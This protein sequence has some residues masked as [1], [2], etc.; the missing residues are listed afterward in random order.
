MTVISLVVFVLGA[1]A[2]SFLNVAIQRVPE[3]ITLFPP[4]STCDQCGSRLQMA[5]R[6][7]LLSFLVLSGRCRSCEGRR[8]WQYPLVELLTAILFVLVWMTYG[9][10]WA[11]LAGWIFATVMVA[12]TI[13][14]IRHMIIPNEVLAAGA[15]LGLPFLAM[16]SLSK[17]AWGLVAG[18][19]LG[20]AMLLIAWLSKGGMGG[21]DIKLAALI[22]LFLGPRLAALAIFMAFL[23][24]GVVG[25]FLLVSKIKGRKD[26]IPFGPYLALG[27]LLALLQ[28]TNIINWYLG[29]WA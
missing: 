17:T 7:P 27:G 4:P 11:T 23:V 20:A 18:L 10:S 14:D 12:I 28:G 26:A 19:S 3:R 13:V 2:G 6:V 5:D 29:L 22:G 24:G 1:Y 15:C 8:S 9:F 21:G 25:A 16:E